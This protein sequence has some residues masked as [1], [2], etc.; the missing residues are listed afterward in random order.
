MIK[1]KFINKEHLG[2]K[3]KILRYKLGLSMEEFGKIFNATKGSVSGWESGKVIPNIERLHQMAEMENI[4]ITELCFSPFDVS[5]LTIKII[6]KIKIKKTIP[7]IFNAYQEE[8]AYTFLSELSYFSPSL[9][10]EEN[11]KAYCQYFEDGYISIKV[12]PRIPFKSIFFDASSDDEVREPYNQILCESLSDQLSTKLKQDIVINTIFLHETC[13][14][15]DLYNADYPS[16]LDNPLI[17][18]LST[19]I[20]SVNI[21]F[22]NRG[23]FIAQ[24]YEWLKKEIKRIEK[25]AAKTKQPKK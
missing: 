22:S 17:K 3:I 11:L 15:E 24:Y 18:K 4:P 1:N 20:S 25:F 12:N 13:F 14:D 9:K 8:M 21:N 16:Y 10:I 6:S 2:L 5:N 7:S 23:Q 19:I